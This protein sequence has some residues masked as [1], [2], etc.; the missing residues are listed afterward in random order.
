[1]EPVNILDARNNLSQLVARASS[2]EEVVIS[3]RGR[4]VVRLVRIDADPGP[5]A[6]SLADWLEAH[7]VPPRAA[8]DRDALDE[9][10]AREREGWE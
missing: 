4:P 8:R 7:P 5:T 2:G 1:V 10:I 3:K 9:Q 6:E